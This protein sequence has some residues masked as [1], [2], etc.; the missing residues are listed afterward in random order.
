MIQDFVLRLSPVNI[1]LNSLSTMAK[2]HKFDP[3]KPAEIVCSGKAVM[4]KKKNTHN[5]V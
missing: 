4:Y 2:Q 3:L 1:I 5:S